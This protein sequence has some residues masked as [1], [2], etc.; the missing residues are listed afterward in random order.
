MFEKYT[1]E[2]IEQL[3][4]EVLDFEKTYL[5]YNS[6]TSWIYTY[7]LRK[8]SAATDFKNFAINHEVRVLDDFHL[9]PDV[10]S[11]GEI[12]LDFR[13]AIPLSEIFKGV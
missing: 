5:I 1:T 4:N 13:K 11:T 2:F 6:K 8:D 9:V 10:S 12:S 3:F 7:L